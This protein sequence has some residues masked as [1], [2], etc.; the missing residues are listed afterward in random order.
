M[1]AA[2]GLEW[3]RVYLMAVNSYSFPSLVMSDNYAGQK[4]FI[5][6][7]LNLEACALAQLYALISGN[8]ESYAEQKESHLA[9]F[10]NAAERLRLLY[11]AITRAREDVIMTWNFG[12]GNQRAGLS[13]PAVY[14]KEWLAEREK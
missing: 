10:E 7:N 12:R 4:W 8:T 9:F 6:D 14:L 13:L 11:V 2:K 1:H 5:R 3:D